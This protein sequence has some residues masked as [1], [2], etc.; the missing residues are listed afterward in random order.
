MIGLRINEAE[1]QTAR[2]VLHERAARDGHFSV[3]HCTPL[4]LRS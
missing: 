4:N 3:R 2:M 1:E